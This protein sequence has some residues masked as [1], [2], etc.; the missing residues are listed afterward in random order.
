[1][2]GICTDVTERKCVE[3]ALRD[4]AQLVETLHR[5]GS[6]LTSGLDLERV[7]QVA[8]DEATKLAGARFGALCCTV[9]SGRGGS[10]TL[11]TIAGARSELVDDLLAWGDTYALDP[12]FREVLRSDDI[13]RDPRRET[14]PPPFPG[15][16]R[17]PVASCLAVPVISHSGEVLGG[18]FLAH[19]EAGVFTARQERLVVDIVSWAALVMDNARLYAAQQRTRSRAAVRPKRRTDG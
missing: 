17:L 6:S 8:T 14:L 1:M 9:A 13:R 7:L 4:E 10:H 3:E 12:S 15:A 11:R 18:L 16:G 2:L 19:P 5:I